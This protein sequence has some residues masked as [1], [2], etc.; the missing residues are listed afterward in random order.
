MML[1]HYLGPSDTSLYLKTL[2]E[3]KSYDKA[4]EAVNQSIEKRTKKPAPKNTPIVDYLETFNNRLSA[5]NFISKKNTT[6]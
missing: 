5:L 4:Q 6:S 2:T 1:Q 3:T